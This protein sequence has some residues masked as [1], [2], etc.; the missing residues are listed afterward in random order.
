MLFRKYLRGRTWWIAII[1][2]IF[3]LATYT[4]MTRIEYK[5]LE[6]GWSQHRLPRDLAELPVRNGFMDKLIDGW[7][8]S[9][10]YLS[11]DNGVV[12]LKSFGADGLP[13]GTG[14][15]SDIERSFSTKDTNGNWVRQ[16]V[17]YR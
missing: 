10:Q 13:G 3:L 2:F 14:N 9:I 16:P 4:R 17:G 11:N 12:V 7:E 1:S 8:R 15:D 5:I 6:F